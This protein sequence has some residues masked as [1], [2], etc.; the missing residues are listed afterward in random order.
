MFPCYKTSF[1]VL[2]TFEKIKLIQ[3]ARYHKAADEDEKSF[4]ECDPFK[5]FHRAFENIKPAFMFMRHIKG[6]TIYMVRP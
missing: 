2:Q 1:N 3:V 5:I 6:G 4:I